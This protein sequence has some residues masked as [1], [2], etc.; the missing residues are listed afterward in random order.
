VGTNGLGAVDL[1]SFVGRRSDLR[2][3]RRLLGHSRLVTLVGPGGIGKTRLARRLAG[4]VARAFPDGTYALELGELPDPKAIV[5]ELAAVLGVEDV[6]PSHD[7]AV[8]SSS[9]PGAS[10]WSST[11]A[12]ASS[13]PRP[14]SSRRCWASRPG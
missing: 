2:E 8:T 3:A 9:A 14:G 1:T 10:S 4:D 6:G 12:S 5:T 7:A 13:R 11:T